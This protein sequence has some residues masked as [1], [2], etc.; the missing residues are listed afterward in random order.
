MQ[1]RQRS[2]EDEDESVRI[3]VR[4]LG[5]MRSGG[6]GGGGGVER[7]RERERSGQAMGASCAWPFFHPSH[8][9]QPVPFHSPSFPFD[10]RGPLHNVRC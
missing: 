2:I 5:D 4:A 6:G 10:G 3:A 1:A 9:S 7:E 8:P